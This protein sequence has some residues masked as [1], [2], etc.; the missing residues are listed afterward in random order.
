M[1]PFHQKKALKS[2]RFKKGQLSLKKLDLLSL[3]KSR[4]LADVTILYNAFHG[5]PVHVT[6]ID[7]E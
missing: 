5:I 4:L 6:D 3:E 1:V 2:W 7:V